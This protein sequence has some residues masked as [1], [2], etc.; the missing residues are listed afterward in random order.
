MLKL[1]PT[2]FLFALM[3]SFTT[4]WSQNLS[5]V[6]CSTVLILADTDDPIENVDSTADLLSMDSV[7]LDQ[8]SF[9]VMLIIQVSD[10]SAVNKI[11]IE[12]GSSVNTNNVLN[13][14]YN[15]DSNTGST[16]IFEPY[17]NYINIVLGEITIDSLLHFKVR[18]EGYQGQFSL[19]FVGTIER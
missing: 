13:Q 1:R 17:D 6:D 10:S 11:H 18:A 9:E 14:Y 7:W 16:L 12:V 8:N 3:G 4:V 19:P 15:E 5:V 2:L